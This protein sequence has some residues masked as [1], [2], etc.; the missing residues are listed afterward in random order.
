MP[1]PALNKQH[2]CVTRLR[3]SP[4]ALF[5]SHSPACVAAEPWLDRALAA[6]R[7]SLRAPSI[8]DDDKPF[9]RHAGFAHDPGGLLGHLVS[10]CLHTLYKTAPVELIILS[11]A[12]SHLCC[13]LVIGSLPVSWLQLGP[14]GELE[15]Y[16]PLLRAPS[17]T[18]RRP[19]GHH[20]VQAPEPR[21]EAWEQQTLLPAADVERQPGAPW[22]VRGA[23][24]A[25]MLCTCKFLTKCETKCILYC[26]CKG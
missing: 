24:V 4:A 7:R 2:Q 12:A 14:S 17:V 21:P 15:H 23:C 6:L 25:L 20:V 10:L 5:R 19:G 3:Q 13:S 1:G 8:A 18:S 22:R 11:W 9:W 16:F 26:M